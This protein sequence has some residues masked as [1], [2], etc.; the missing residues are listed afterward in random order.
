MSS[1]MSKNIKDFETRL[2]KATNS[3]ANARQRALD[4]LEIEAK[5]QLKEVQSLA[6]ALQTKEERLEKVIYQMENID[7]YLA[8]SSKK[9]KAKEAQN[10]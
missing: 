6:K 4:R 10:D 5:K 1:E 9:S 3:G 8:N 7:E 2:N